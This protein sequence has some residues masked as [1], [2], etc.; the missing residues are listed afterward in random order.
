M[1]IN[2]RLRVQQSIVQRR[3]QVAK[4][5]EHI[6]QQVRQKPGFKNFLRAESETYLLSAA[7]EGPIVV[8]NDSKLRIDAIIITKAG[9]RS[10]ALPCLSTSINEYLYC[11][12]GICTVHDSKDDNQAKR[13]S[14]EWLWK[15][16]VQPVLRELGFY[17]KA[18]DPLPRV[19]WIGVGIMAKAPIHAAAKFKNGRIQMTTLQFCIPSYTSTIRYIPS[20]QV[21]LCQ[22][23]N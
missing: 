11:G 9:V 13:E 15:A 6:L 20:L 16:A 19:W 8:L 10:I 12:T 2:Q 1:S 14:L 23:L 3:N 4:D 22:V 7:Q 17:L 5:L 18:A 21:F